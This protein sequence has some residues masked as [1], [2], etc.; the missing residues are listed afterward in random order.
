MKLYVI[1]ILAFAAVV[2]GIYV[3]RGNPYKQG[4]LKVGQLTLSETI[5]GSPLHT[6]A[7]FPLEAGD[8][9]VVFFLGGLNT[10]VLAELY[11]TVLSSI[12][13]HGFFVF[14]VDY[15]FPVYAQ[16]LKPEKNNYGKQDIDKFFKE[17]TWLENYFKNRTVSTPA[18]NSTG[19]LC[20]SSGCDVSVKMIKEKRSLFT[21]TIFME[22]FTTEVDTPIKN[23]MPALMYGTQLSEEGLKCSIPGRDYN[24]LYEIWSC[25]RIVMNVANFGHC[26]MLDPVGWEGCHLTHFCKTTNDTFLA[27]YRQFV[28]GVA[29]SFF[30][31]TLQ[32]LT[33][34]ISYVT[35]KNLI[36]LELLELKSDINCI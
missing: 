35:V 26:D 34:D 1:S 24:K 10:Y 23:G 15:Q 5:T 4:P 30:I 22:P 19:L 13:S 27:E 28:Q 33:K 7:F 12:A 11:T 6:L 21:S 29:S 16:K 14:G 17:L 2:S 20:H 25:P 18:F 32:G 36:P 3:D 8:Y 9:P 31:S